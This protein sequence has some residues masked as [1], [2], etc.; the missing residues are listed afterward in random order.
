MR[1]IP[2]LFRRDP[3]DLRR[4]TR[5]V[6]PDCAWV[7]AGE[8]VPTRK[9]DGTCVRLDESGRWY[10]RREVKP[11]KATPA[12]FEPVQTDP[13]TG[14]TVGW[15]PAEQSSFARYLTEAVE[16]GG[17]FAPGPYELCGPKING[18]PEGY[19][20]HV[21]VRHEIAEE[22]REVPRDFDGLVTYLAGLGHEGIVWHHPDGRMAKLKVRDFPRS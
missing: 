1:K 11:G 3:E 12:G 22:L 18:N 19:P 6:N 20:G 14:K 10:A 13:V 16:R 7:L 4:V 5:E 17:P 9:F 21:L 8:G 15:E 2:T